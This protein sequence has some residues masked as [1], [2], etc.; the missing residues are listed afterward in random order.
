MKILIDHQIFSIQTY[1]GISRYFYELMQQ[2]SGRHDIRF[3][4]PVIL[5]NNIYLKSAEFS[6]HY[7]VFDWLKI[8]GQRKLISTVNGIYCSRAIH[9]GNYE[10]LHPTYYDP[11]FLNYIGGKPFVLTIYDM[12]HEKFPLIYKSDPS[13]L[14]KK[15]LAQKASHIIAIS[16]N[17]KKDIVEIF[18]IDER[19]ISVVH[20]A[21]SLCRRSTSLVN[22]MKLPDTFL[23]YVGDRAGYKNFDVFIKAASRLL[24]NDEA[25]YVVCGGGGNFNKDETNLLVSHGI[26]DRVLHYDV[27]DDR[28]A[29][30]YSKALAFVFPSL[31]EGF[32]IPLLE[33]MS[34]GC[35]VVCSNSSSLSEVAGSAGEYFDPTDSDSMQ[36]AIGN[37]I[38]SQGRKSELIAR[39][40][41]RCRIFTWEKCAEETLAVYRSLCN[42]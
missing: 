5:S 32:G 25:L 13:L 18:G 3:D 34:M 14:S 8:K 27:N 24:L 29:R 4:L 42:Q 15:M 39:G 16:N 31:Y 11:Y 10:I 19:K 36:A 6:N 1:G 26:S 35:P 12:I 20:L 40:L 23:L 22:G 38:Q 28:L 41:E 2:F 9:K 17:T 21:T 37:V 33:A 7:S 30:M